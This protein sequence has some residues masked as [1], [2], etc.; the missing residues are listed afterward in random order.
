MVDSIESRIKRRM[1]ESPS[2]VYKSLAEQIERL[3]EQAVKNA[4]QSIEFLKR[5]LD[6]AQQVVKADRMAEDGTLDENEALV[7]PHIGAL[8]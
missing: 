6:I 2:K 7:D 8:T 4:D 3:R 1:E 5:A